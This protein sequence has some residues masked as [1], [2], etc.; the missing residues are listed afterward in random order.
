M[1]IR[2]ICFVFLSIASALANFGLSQSEIN[3]PYN[4]V[5][6]DTSLQIAVKDTLQEPKVNIYISPNPFSERM[7][8]RL[9]S[10]DSGEYILMLSNNEGRILV[11]QP[12]RLISGVERIIPIGE[13]ITKGTYILTLEWEGRQIYHNRIIKE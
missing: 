9:R 4:H 5:V 7:L 13:G 10:S 2:G 12:G 6:P 11:S 1:L 8:V 3:G